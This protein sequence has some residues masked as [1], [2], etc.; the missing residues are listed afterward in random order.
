MDRRTLTARLAAGPETF[1]ALTRGLD[2]DD[3]HWRPGPDRWSVVEVIAHLADEERLDFR[4][5]LELTLHDPDRDWPPIDPEGWVRDHD[6]Q[7]RRLDEVLEDFV[8]ERRASLSWLDGLEE[9]RF[10]RAHEHPRLG[11]LRAG[12]LLSAWVV[13]DLLHV[14][15]LTALHRA[16]VLA[17]TAP[18][19]ADYAGP[20]SGR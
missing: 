7:A 4:M 14:R 1:S 6:Y 2:E 20:W 13:H 15:Q 19:S 8:T 16:R 5:R 11:P 3:A 18:Y 10:D 9:P 17:D 12:D